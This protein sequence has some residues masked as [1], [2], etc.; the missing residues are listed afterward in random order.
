MFLLPVGL[1]ICGLGC[2]DGAEDPARLLDS[3]VD[4]RLDRRTDL[5]RPDSQR[6]D[7]ARP[8]ASEPLPVLVPEGFFASVDGSPEAPGTFDEPWNLATALGE[9]I[10]EN[11]SGFGPGDTLWIRG[12]TYR[13]E[14]ESFLSG[15]E[16][17][18]VHIRPFPREH[19]RI[20]GEKL[21]S[22]RQD[23]LVISGAY[24]WFYDLE[25]TGTDGTEYR[26]GEEGRPPP[27]TGSVK[28]R[29]PHAKV[30]DFIVH[31][32]SMGMSS[33]VSADGGL[34][35]GAEF[36]GGAWFANGWR[37]YGSSRDHGHGGYLQNVHQNEPI[38]ARGATFFENFNLAI[39]CRS[40]S[41]AAKVDRFHLIGNMIYRSIGMFEGGGSDR[42]NLPTEHVFDENVLFEST[43]RFGQ[44]GLHEQ[45]FA[46]G[47]HWWSSTLEVL[48]VT[49]F[50]I[51]DNRFYRPS[52][53]AH[54]I[55]QYRTRDDVPTLFD[56]E[57]RIDRNRYYGVD[58]FH[59]RGTNDFFTNS[60]TSAIAWDEW[61]RHNDQASSRAPLSTEPM[62]VYRS[63]PYV[64]RRGSIA[65]IRSN[66]EAVVPIDLSELGFRS[67]DRYRIVFAFDPVLQGDEGLGLRIHKEGT[68]DG[69][70]V[71]LALDGLSI[72]G[73]NGYDS[74]GVVRTAFR[75]DFFVFFVYE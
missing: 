26:G 3:S 55:V 65:L 52:G 47:N 44:A 25:I 31:N 6:P 23:A 56:P 35:T 34:A 59:G 58:P 9:S 10:R 71:R 16:D 17:D 62:L 57:V 20:D 41:G 30:I 11:P 33:S 4:A 72:A 68:F 49:D 37:Q 67:G 32:T 51:V 5:E 36:Y 15:T 42:S 69:E 7:A 73:K 61:I 66:R 46:R 28:I 60:G 63:N 27:T 29:A 19:V 74:P 24:S 2:A 8:D 75:D 21:A 64:D 18:P 13:G 48:N 53:A 54:S 39:Q 14:F 1:A 45:N 43:F 38:V 50:E 22:D 12:G 70:L 40:S